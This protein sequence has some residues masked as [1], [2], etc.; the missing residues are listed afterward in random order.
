MSLNT[1]NEGPIPSVVAMIL[2]KFGLTKEKAPRLARAMVCSEDEKNIQRAIKAVEEDP[3]TPIFIVSVG[4]QNV[5]SRNSEIG[6]L[7]QFPNVRIADALQFMPSLEVFSGSR[8]A[9]FKLDPEKAMSQ[10]LSGIRHDLRHALNG[11]TSYSK[12][13]LLEKARKKLGFEGDD[14]A[15]IKRV[16]EPK[17]LV[18][19]KEY[20]NVAGVF[21]DWDGTLKRNS[22]FD[23]K[24]FAH[25]QEVSKQKG[26]PLVIWTGGDPDSVYRELD[27][28]GIRGVN[29]CSKQDCKGFRVAVAI[30]DEPLE[31]LKNTYGIDAKG[32]ERVA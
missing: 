30:D 10:T 13:K 28:L 15:L 2:D 25:A 7:A 31:S 16:M 12:E 29:V 27:A 8:E 9:N 26:L 1:P 23:P 11:S 19:V 6:Y 3:A 4:P 24:A 5:L 17:S 18:E 14:E 22:G 21:V 20:R 32:F